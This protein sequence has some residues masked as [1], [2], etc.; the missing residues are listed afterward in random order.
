MDGSAIV[1]RIKSLLIKNGKTMQDLIR[2]CRIS[3]AAISQWN[4]GRTQPRMRKLE[5]I[6]KYLDT[7]VTFLAYGIA[8]SEITFAFRLDR[9]MSDEE[10]EAARKDMEDY[11]RFL[12]SK[13]S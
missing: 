13:K 5:E 6:A 4:T 12:M 9:D 1:K 10:I 11:W 3:S 2:D 7:D 8:P